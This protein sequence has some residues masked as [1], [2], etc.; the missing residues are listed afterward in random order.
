M[1]WDTQ[2]DNLKAIAEHLRKDPRIVGVY[3]EY[4]AYLSVVINEESENYIYY[5]YDTSNDEQTGHLAMSWNDPSGHYVGEFDTMV[6]PED[7]A[8][9]LITQLEENGIFTL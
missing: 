8:Q 4:P 7:N 1:D 2:I 6:R 3:L 9:E 5:G